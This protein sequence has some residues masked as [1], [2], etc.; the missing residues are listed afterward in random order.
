MGAIGKAVMAAII[1]LVL[2]AKRNS[3]V[4]V[5]AVGSSDPRSKELKIFRILV[6]LQLCCRSAV[7]V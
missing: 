2:A 3:A 6:G 7:L 1:L 5:L 4:V